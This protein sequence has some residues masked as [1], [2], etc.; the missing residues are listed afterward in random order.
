[1]AE[2]GREVANIC[3]PIINLHYSNGFG[4][5]QTEARKYL[6]EK[7][8]CARIITHTMDRAINDRWKVNSILIKLF[9]HF[10]IETFSIWKVK[11]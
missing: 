10:L 8:P 6:F 11:S 4:M 2:Q 9:I 7:N 3:K 1:M 5:Y